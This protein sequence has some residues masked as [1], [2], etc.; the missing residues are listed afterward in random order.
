MLFDPWNPAYVAVVDLS[1]CTAFQVVVVTGIVCMLIF[2]AVLSYARYKH[3]I[4]T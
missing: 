4:G 3:L 2:I 1:F